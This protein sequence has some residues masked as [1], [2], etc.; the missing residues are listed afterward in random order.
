MPKPQ[1]PQ[2]Q[3]DKNAPR[4]FTQQVYDKIA[5]ESIE[6]NG[7]KIQLDPYFIERSQ[8][9]QAGNSFAVDSCKMKM[10]RKRSP[11]VIITTAICLQ[12]LH[13]E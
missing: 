13:S 2:K 12:M 7:K 10:V 9:S 5:S 6:Y 3:V 4:S 11:N 8:D 1:K